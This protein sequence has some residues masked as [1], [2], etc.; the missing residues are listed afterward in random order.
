MIKT[1]FGRSGNADAYLVHCKL[2][3]GRTPRDF[4][5]MHANNELQIG[6]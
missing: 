2:A 5:R 1:F 4:S 3:R 6:P